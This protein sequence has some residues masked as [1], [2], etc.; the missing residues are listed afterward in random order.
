MSQKESDNEQKNG[1]EPYK[2][3]SVRRSTKKKLSNFKNNIGVSWDMMMRDFVEM[4][5]EGDVSERGDLTHLKQT[6]T[7]WINDGRKE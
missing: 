7:E 6:F 2:M 4:L 5:E 3:I 1:N